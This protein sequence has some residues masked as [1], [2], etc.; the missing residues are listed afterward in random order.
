MNKGNIKFYLIFLFA[1]ILGA[2]VDYLFYGKPVG[3]SFFVFISVFIIFSLILTKKFRQKLIKIQYV[4]LIPAILFSIMVFYRS[5]SFL[6]FFNIVGTLFLIFLLFVLFSNK[7]LYNF[8]LLKYFISPLSFLVK[9][10][11]KSARFIE[12]NIDRIQAKKKIGS[13]EFRSVIR[14]IIIS[15]P[16]L[17]LLIWLLSSADIVFQRYLEKIWQISIDPE[18]VLRILIVLVASYFFIGIFAKVFTDKKPENSSIENNQPQFLG[19]IESSVILGAIGL[20]FLV[21]ISIQFVYLFGGR[22]Y[23]WGIEEYITYSEY[24][25]KGFGE[26]IAVSII[27][28]LLIYGIDKF[29]KRENIFQKRT[30]KI[31]SSILIFETFVIM[32]SAF[33]RLAL[34][35]DGYSFTLSRLLSFIFLFWLFSVF[36]IFLYKIFSEQKET[37]FIFS[38]FWLIILFWAGVNFLNPDAFIAKKNIE[39][40]AQGKQLDTWYLSALSEDALPEIVKIFE[41][42]NEEN[43]IKG[44]VACHLNRQKEHL[45]KSLKAQSWQSL[46]LSKKRAL[47]ILQKHSPEIEK[48]KE[49]YAQILKDYNLELYELAKREDWRCVPIKYFKKD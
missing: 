13:P 20:L 38:A 11:G 47:E 15:V 24:A 17:A 1:I 36:L 43:K 21:F 5:T 23:V 33:T 6:T 42:R 28:F 18:I 29:G 9:S 35:I 39:K 44:E 27:S 32:A 49:I 16:I 41:L 10:F 2:S 25:R 26:L 45:S 4:L 40:Y 22:D 31:L 3:I 7:N 37:R 30:F 19:S 8:D 48:Y 46:N 12:E 34:Y 14:G